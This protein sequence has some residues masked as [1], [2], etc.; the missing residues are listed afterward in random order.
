M[1]VHHTRFINKK[2]GLSIQ[3]TD[4]DPQLEG[5]ALKPIFLK[6]LFII[7]KTLSSLYILSLRTFIIHNNIH[8]D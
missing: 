1:Q 7:D 2:I 4:I 8:C 6:L 5:N 3:G